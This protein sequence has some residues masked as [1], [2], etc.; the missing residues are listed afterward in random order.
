MTRPTVVL[1]SINGKLTVACFI[2]LRDDQHECAKLPLHN[3]SM[4]QSRLRTVRIDDEWT[5]AHLL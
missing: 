3:L 5:T 1:Q 2:R 4:C